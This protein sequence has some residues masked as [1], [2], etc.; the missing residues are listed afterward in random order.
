MYMV[1]VTVVLK[2]F[3]S[4]LTFLTIP[5]HDPCQLC[6]RK[7]KKLVMSEKGIFFSWLATFSFIIFVRISVTAD[8]IITHKNYSK[9]ILSDVI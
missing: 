1:I 2:L 3:N 8:K 9:I 7:K 6:K 5:F 4:G